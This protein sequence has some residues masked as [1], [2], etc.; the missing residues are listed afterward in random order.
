MCVCVCVCNVCIPVDSSWLGWVLCS[1]FPSVPLSQCVVVVGRCTVPHASLLP[2]L[3]ASLFED[4]DKWFGSRGSFFSFHP[5]CGSFQCNPPFVDGIMTLA[6][7]HVVHLLAGA[8]SNGQAM[9]FVVVLPDW[10]A[11]SHHRLMSTRFLVHT[12]LWRANHHQC[13]THMMAWA[14]CGAQCVVC[15][16]SCELCKCREVAVLRCFVALGCLAAALTLSTSCVSLFDFHVGCQ[17]QRRLP[18]LHR[19]SGVGG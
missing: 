17:V 18:A 14:V 5:R 8:E 6:A 7:A 1:T 16:V 11:E 3:L 9:S 4:T 2:S 15:G 13:V 10:H 12:E 19:E